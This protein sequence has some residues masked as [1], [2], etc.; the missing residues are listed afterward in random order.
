VQWLL[1]GEQTGLGKLEMQIGQMKMQ[2]WMGDILSLSEVEQQVQLIGL[3]LQVVQLE[4]EHGKTYHTQ[5]HKRLS[6]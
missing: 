6:Q 2:S 3:T 1:E 4:H 5:M